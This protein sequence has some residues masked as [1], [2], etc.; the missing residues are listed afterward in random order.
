MCGYN[1]ESRQD[2]AG[3]NIDELFKSL[4]PDGQY[5]AKIT[6]IKPYSTTE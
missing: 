4:T 6:T 2:L 1:L 5:A 3:E